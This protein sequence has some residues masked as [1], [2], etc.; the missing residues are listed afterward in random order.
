[1]SSGVWHTSNLIW[2]NFSSKGFR[3][4]K[5]MKEERLDFKIFFKIRLITRK[6]SA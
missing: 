6:L 5:D 3:K 2:S 1:M 4:T